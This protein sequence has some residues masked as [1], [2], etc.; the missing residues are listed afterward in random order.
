MLEDFVDALTDE[1]SVDYVEAIWGDH[2][3]AHARHCNYKPWV[4]PHGIVYCLTC[5]S[6]VS[7]LSHEKVGRCRRCDHPL[8]AHHPETGRCLMCRECQGARE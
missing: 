8:T 4:N 3:Q 6:T 7:S 5:E 2:G 1:E